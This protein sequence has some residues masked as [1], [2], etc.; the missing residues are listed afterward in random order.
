MNNVDMSDWG[1]PS[2][3]NYPYDAPS[4]IE[5]IQAVEECITE[6]VLPGSAGATKWKL[7]IAANALKIAVREIERGNS[8]R[9][10][11]ETIFNDLEVIDEPDLSR[12][13]KEGDYDDRFEMLQ[14]KLLSIVAMKLEVANP[15][16]FKSVQNP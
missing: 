12:K 5:L 2:R 1:L 13:I 9:D 8:H 3:T 7:R 14:E 4:A 11:L 15:S 16:Y 10:A 6:E